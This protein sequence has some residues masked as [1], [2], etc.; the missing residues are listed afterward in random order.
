MNR[1][2]RLVAS[3]FEVLYLLMI[4]IEYCSTASEENS[5]PVHMF[6]SRRIAIR[7]LILCILLQ[8]RVLHF[9]CSIHK[10]IPTLKYVARGTVKAL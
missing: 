10:V 4:V 3:N 5:H 6:I 9:T 8:D 7:Q 1:V 2:L